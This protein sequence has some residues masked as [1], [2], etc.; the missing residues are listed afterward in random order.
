MVSPHELERYFFLD[1]RDRSLAE[2]KRRDHYKIRFCLQLMT[3]RYVGALLD[4]PLQVPVELLGYV[5]E[6]LGIADTLTSA[7]RAG[8]GSSFRCCSGADSGAVKSVHGD[9]QDVAPLFQV[10][11]LHG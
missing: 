8:C 2:A 1:D 5:A 9:T 7:N 6:Q 4:D 10:L 3:V 11:L